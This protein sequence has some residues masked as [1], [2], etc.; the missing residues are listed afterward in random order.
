MTKNQRLLLKACLEALGFTLLVIS[1]IGVSLL[2]GCFFGPAGV[3]VCLTI[4][5]LVFAIWA[6]Y[7]DLKRYGI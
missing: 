6:R 3:V 5:A 2:T 4:G 1:L 7:D